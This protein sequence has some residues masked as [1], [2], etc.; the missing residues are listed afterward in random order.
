MENTKKMILWIC[1]LY[2]IS[3]IIGEKKYE[4]VNRNS[5]MSPKIEK[6]IIRLVKTTY[7]GHYLNLWNVS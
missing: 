5:V 4:G 3:K 7:G 6:K 1:K 2:R